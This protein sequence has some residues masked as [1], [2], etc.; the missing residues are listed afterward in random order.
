MRNESAF[1]YRESIGLRTRSKNLGFSADG[2]LFSWLF[3]S[4]AVSP[5]PGGTRRYERF[6]E[7]QSFLNWQIGRVM[8]VMGPD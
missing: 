4:L 5:T 8:V 1:I 7:E 3:M 2:G 6:H